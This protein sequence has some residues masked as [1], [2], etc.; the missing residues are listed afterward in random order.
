MKEFDIYKYLEMASLIDSNYKLLEQDPS[1]EELF[2]NLKTSLN[3][4]YELI[5]K[6]IIPGK[7]IYKSLEFHNNYYRL[8][9]KTYI[10]KN[11]Q[12]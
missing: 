10:P 5:E 2:L 9:S 7:I 3:A 4:F 11:K 12:K 6:R 1:N 8:M